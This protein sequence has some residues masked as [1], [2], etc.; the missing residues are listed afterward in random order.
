MR[1]LLKTLPPIKT[2]LHVSAAALIVLSAASAARAHRP[3]LERSLHPGNTLES[4][5]QLADP[6]QA[7]QAVYG[8]LSS[9]SE[10]DFYKFNA[11][12]PDAIPFEALV[13]VRPSDREFRPWLV[14]IGKSIAA[15]PDVQIPFALPEGY[16]AHVIRPPAARAYFYEP[17]SL[18]Y[19]YRGTEEK[20]QLAEGE[21][22]YV[23][24]FD[25]EHRVGDYSLGLGSVENFEGASKV[26]MAANV[27]G[28][29]LG[30]AG[31]AALPFLDLL[32]VFVSLVGFSVGLGTTFFSFAAENLLG[33]DGRGAR[34]QLVASRLAWLGLLAALLGSALLYRES[35]L[36]GVAAFQA[37]LF[38]AIVLLQIY[39][40]IRLSRRARRAGA[41]P[42]LP[43]MP[44]PKPFKKLTVSH[45]LT[46]LCWCGLIFFFAWY[47]LVLR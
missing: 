29:K 45:A 5:A 30:I 9:P 27:L 10:V 38:A 39:L 4:A 42:Q 33:S 16:Q 28:A 25:P 43:G 18:E 22:Y 35:V 31:G 47:A 36:S 12:K 2:L 8:R 46:L 1:A 19:L 44:A 40:A 15:T 11:S 7:S 41:E 20:L 24:V 26:S 6:T 23:A 32:A 13:P 21:T 34:A 3:V 14:V 17:Y 37:A